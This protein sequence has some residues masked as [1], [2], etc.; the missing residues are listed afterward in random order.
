MRYLLIFLWITT[1]DA[2]T[3]RERVKALPDLRLAMHLCGYRDSNMELFTQRIERER[4]ESVITCLESKTPE[5]DAII[6]EDNVKE[7]AYEAALA[8]I[9]A[10]DCSTLSGQILKDLCVINKQK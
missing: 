1:I 10:L 4:L 3:I 9:K 8:R 2:A 6:A 7:T 5:V